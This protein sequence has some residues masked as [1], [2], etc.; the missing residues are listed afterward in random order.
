[1]S[2]PKTDQKLLNPLL[3]TIKKL[4]EIKTKEEN[5]K[6]LAGMPPTTVSPGAE[7]VEAVQ[8][9]P[10]LTLDLKTE[11]AIEDQGKNALPEKRMPLVNLLL[12]S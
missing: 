10:I 6:L 2:G 1:M 12:S 11:E 5:K 7:E 9:P 3:R 4:G 8:P